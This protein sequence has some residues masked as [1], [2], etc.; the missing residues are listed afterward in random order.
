MEKDLKCNIEEC[1]FCSVDSKHLFRERTLCDQLCNLERKGQGSVESGSE[2]AGWPRLLHWSRREAWES[3]PEA[4][5]QEPLGQKRLQMFYLACTIFLNCQLQ[6]GRFHIKMFPISNFFWKIR[7]SGHPGPTVLQSTVTWL[8]LSSSSWPLRS[9]TLA[10][11]HRRPH[12]RLEL[13]ATKV[14]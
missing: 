1:V 4:E 12:Y 2:G 9:E 10:R 3:K 6:T 13:T 8:G 7:R 14:G 11:V 5:N